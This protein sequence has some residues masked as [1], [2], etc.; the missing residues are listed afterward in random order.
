MLLAIMRKFLAK[1]VY[2]FAGKQHH[3]SEAVID[4]I[5]HELNPAM[6]EG[7]KGA[8]EKLYNDLMYGVGVK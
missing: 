6:S 8:N 1:Q 3:L 2:P 5:M 4:K 7:L